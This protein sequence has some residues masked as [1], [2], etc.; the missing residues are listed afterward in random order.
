MG[1]DTLEDPILQLGS[2]CLVDQLVGQYMSHVLGLGYLVK[3][4]NVKKTLSSIMKY[5]YKEG[6]YNHFNQM[7]TYVVN[8][9]SALLMASYPHGNR[10]DEP[11]PYYNEVMTGFEHS[12]A[13]H[14]LYEDKID[15]GLKV[16]QAIRDRYDGFKR[17]PFDEAECGHHYARAMA[18][19]AEL[20]ALTGFHYSAVSKE[21]TLAAQNG[22]FFWSNG[23]AWGTC[24]LSKGGNKWTVEL[25]VLFGV[26]N[27]KNFI[28][29]D[30]GSYGVN[31]DG[32]DQ[33]NLITFTI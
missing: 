13:A 18:S 1:S 6:F 7:R 15:E 20:L 26:I 27:I 25:H 11:F 22:Q 12:T 4:E 9:E 21:M 23:S 24:T 30:M 10:P 33:N 14:M 16:I 3:V 5:N 8:D 32:I 28:L 19:W 17:N 29:T 31:Q 2:G